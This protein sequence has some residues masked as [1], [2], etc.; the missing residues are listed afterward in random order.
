MGTCFHQVR[1]RFPYTYR[2]P[3]EDKKK[4]SQYKAKKHKTAAAKQMETWATTGEDMTRR[5]SSLHTDFVSRNALQ[6]PMPHILEMTWDT[7]GSFERSVARLCML[8]PRRVSGKIQVVHG[9]SNFS[10]LSG[11]LRI[12]RRIVFPRPS[13]LAGSRL[14]RK[15]MQR[16]RF[17]WNGTLCRE[18]LAIVFYCLHCIWD[19]F[20]LARTTATDIWKGCGG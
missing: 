13:N 19:L 18:K 1:I 11:Q 6:H 15:S 16:Q 10:G 7:F 4:G 20:C 17:V 5:L 14:Y 12:P 8:F 3:Q 9:P 2:A